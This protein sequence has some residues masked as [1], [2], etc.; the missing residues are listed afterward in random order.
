MANNT[1]LTT[2]DI[3]T[4]VQ[5]VMDYE[6]VANA[7]EKMPFLGFMLAKYGTKDKQG[8][9]IPDDGILASAK[10]SAI[11]RREIQSHTWE[12][13]MYTGLPADDTK[14]MAW[15]DTTADVSENASTA[16]S[17][18]GRTVRPRFRRTNK[19]T[20]V[21]IWKR[22]L[23]Q[24]QN[25]YRQARATG[26]RAAASA[27]TKDVR[28]LVQLAVTEK[29]QLQL[30]GWNADIFG[31]TD[32]V[33]TTSTNLLWDKQYSLRA[34]MG[35][36]GMF[37]GIDRD[38]AGNEFAHGNVVTSNI[39]ADIDYLYDYMQY[40]GLALSNY[41]IEPT[42]WLCGNVLFTKFK[43]QAKEKNIKVFTGE[44]IPDM[45]SFGQK[46]EVLLYNGR[47]WIVNE[48]SLASKGMNNATKS[49]LICLDPEQIVVSFF[50]GKSFALSEFDDES[51]RA[52][53][54]KA[55]A[56]V[57]E[58]EV[59]FWYPNPFGMGVYFEDVG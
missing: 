13:I 57:I 48:P 20:P 16:T 6:L 23:E 18:L 52:G 47:I 30:K 42:L 33:P 44:A 35:T 11:K 40:T 59:G 51:K 25:A 1:E 49:P 28:D 27:I 38:V 7:N 9:R 10:V 19:E 36:S 4:V 50:P 54:R 2:A 34:A 15:Y 21:L 32:Q 29:Y 3:R 24:L 45:P 39:P 41:A 8:L 26:N 56:A 37:A 58:T 31:G 14:V 55:L 17:P 5:N 46:R 12:P 22:D 43:A 53:G